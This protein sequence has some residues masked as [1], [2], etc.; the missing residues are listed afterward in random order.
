MVNLIQQCKWNKFN[1]R[2]VKTIKVMKMTK[3]FIYF[4]LAWL[5]NISNSL[6]SICR[7]PRALINKRALI[8]DHRNISLN[9]RRMFVYF[10]E[11]ICLL[12]SDFDHGPKIFRFWLQ[13]SKLWSRLYQLSVKIQTTNCMQND[14]TIKTKLFC[15]ISL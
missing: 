6:K 13:K 3:I 7:A 9:F 15:K 8:C 4:N 14:H 12:L 2:K 11:N 10:Q 5:S 1:R